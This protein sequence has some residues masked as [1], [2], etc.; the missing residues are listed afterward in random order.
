MYDIYQKESVAPVSNMMR[1]M[2][3]N[4]LLIQIQKMKVDSIAMLMSIDDVM[5]KN[6][7]TMLGMA[8]A[9]AAGFLYL[10]LSL[11]LRLLFR[12]KPVDL[13]EEVLRAKASLTRIDICLL[14]ILRQR[15]ADARLSLK[16]DGTCIYLAAEVHREVREL[17]ELSTQLMKGNA[18]TSGLSSAIGAAEMG[19]IKKLLQLLSWAGSS[20]E[21]RLSV[22]ARMRS[23]SVFK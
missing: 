17:S 9:P 3:S 14:R 1:G 5:Q 2:L 11:L 8:A 19:E 16:E 6:E 21:S 10:L 7:L 22:V 13:T 20:A 4:S 12:R 23:I 18:P 15:A